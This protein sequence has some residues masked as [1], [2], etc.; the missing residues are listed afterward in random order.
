MIEPSNDNEKL[1]MRFFALLSE[2]KLDEVKKIL[3]PD[4]T[5]TPYV[6]GITSE[7]VHRGRDAIID[8][9]IGPIRSKL[10][11]NG[12]LRVA[13][14]TL[15]SKANT[16]MA[17]TRAIGIAHNGRSYENHYAWAIEIRD[18]HFVVVREYMD[19]SLCKAGIGSLTARRMG[20]RASGSG[21]NHEQ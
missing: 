15:V 11:R 18:A 12:D 10:F 20:G 14:D 4:A 5:W 17:E 2:G 19:G 7:G 1:V 21:A 16:V 9:F 3:D 13:V 8:D 6:S